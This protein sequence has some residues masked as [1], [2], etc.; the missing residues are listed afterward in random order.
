MRKK[1]ITAAAI[2]LFTGLSCIATGCGMI[3]VYASTDQIKEVMKEKADFKDYSVEVT[4][5]KNLKVDVAVSGVV[6]NE[7]DKFCVNCHQ[8][9]AVKLDIDVTGDTLYV[10]ED[11]KAEKT[12]FDYGFDSPKIEITVPKGTKLSRADFEIATGSLDVTGGSFEDFSADISVGECKLTGSV[13]G[14]IKADCSTGAIKVTD[15]DVKSGRLRTSV[16]AVSG[17]FLHE[18]TF[19]ELDLDA[20]VG[21]VR[22]DGQPKD[23]KYNTHGDNSLSIETSVGGIDI[24]FAG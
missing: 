20:G 6:F 8:P 24:N 19:Y 10:L 2:C 18:V 16:G 1:I 13:I 11:K 15:L 17:N 7:G 9:D 12:V 3:R 23:T 21:G 22:V 14:N 5:F 4:E